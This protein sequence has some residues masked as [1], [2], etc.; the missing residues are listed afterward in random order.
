SLVHTGEA[1]VT[2]LPTHSL[3]VSTSLAYSYLID[4]AAFSQHGIN[5]VAQNLSREASLSWE[6]EVRYLP[7]KDIEAYAN[8][9]LTHTVRSFGEPSYQARLLGSSGNVYPRAIG[10]AGLRVAPASW[11]QVALLGSWVSSRRASDD[12]ALPAGAVYEL[13]SYFLAGATV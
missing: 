11:L 7:T 5:K 13:P 1:Q 3:N 4:Q 6:T 10:N 12:N 8:L 2:L 9:G